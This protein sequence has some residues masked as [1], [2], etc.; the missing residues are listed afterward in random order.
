M[1][2]LFDEFV[3]DGVVG[4]H[5]RG[6]GE[7]AVGRIRYGYQI[8]QDVARDVEHLLIASPFGRYPVE[9]VLPS[10]DGANALLEA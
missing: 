9:V 6:V 2:P 1:K 3:R 10:G 7:Q 4:R 5:V 8:A